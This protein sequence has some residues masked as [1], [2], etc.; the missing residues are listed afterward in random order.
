MVMNS[1]MALQNLYFFHSHF[2]KITT[3]NFVS[4]TAEM[5]QTKAHSETQDN[6]NFPA[7]IIIASPD[8]FAK[9][10]LSLFMAE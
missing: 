1:E 4:V 8:I 3:F 10:A 7:P 2:I 9:T 5:Y 6:P